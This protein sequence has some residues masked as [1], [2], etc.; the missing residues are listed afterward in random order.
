VGIPERYLAPE[1]VVTWLEEAGFDLIRRER[2]G[3][4]MVIAGRPAPATG[5]AARPL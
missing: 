1:S 2:R 4:T 3:P 5:R